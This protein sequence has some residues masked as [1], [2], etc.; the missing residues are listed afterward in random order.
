MPTAAKL[1]AALVFAAIGY[2]V[3]QRAVATLPD[4]AEVGWLR[5]IMAV[6]GFFLGWKLLGPAAQN[7]LSVT[8]AAGLTTS[9]ALAVLGVMFVAIYQ[10]LVK[11]MHNFYKGPMQAIE[12]VFD[13]AWERGQVLADPLIIVILLCGG[14]VAG[15]LARG[16]AKLWR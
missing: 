8:L 1:V 5:E 15:A 10:M 4:N 3:A 14:L 11:S 12:S 13:L 9:V 2:L 7:R 6:F 16:A